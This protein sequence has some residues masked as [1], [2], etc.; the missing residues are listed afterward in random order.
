MA[1]AVHDRSIANR[2]SFVAVSPVG[3]AG[4]VRAAAAIAVPH[5]D[6]SLLPA[7]SSAYTHTFLPTVSGV[8]DTVFGET[9]GSTAVVEKLSPPELGS[10]QPAAVVSVPA[11]SSTAYFATFAV[12]SV[13]VIVAAVPFVGAPDGNAMPGSAVSTLYPLCADM[14][15]AC[16]NTVMALPASS[17]I[18]A[19]AP[20]VMPAPAAT[21][22]PSLSFSPL[23]IVWVYI[24]KEL[25][26]PPIDPTPGPSA[27]RLNCTVLPPILTASVEAPTRSMLSLKWTPTFN[28]APARSHGPDENATWKLL[29]VGHGAG[30]TACPQAPGVA[31]RH[32]GR[33]RQGQG[34]G[35]ARALEGPGCHRG[36]RR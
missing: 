6:E 26:S 30:R 11:T 12:A 14:P 7:A 24:L 18:D 17:L 34:H 27:R 2:S 9:A 36:T 3:A 31:R 35:R 22:T 16:V 25:Y 19:P 21:L 32:G 10:S 5:S 29:I 33:T 8:Y 1:G 28:C 20:S 13:S 4:A 15:V 23:A